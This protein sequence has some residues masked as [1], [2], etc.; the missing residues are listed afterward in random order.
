MRNNAPNTV[1]LAENMIVFCKRPWKLPVFGA[2]A[3]LVMTIIW[4]FYIL[5][6]YDRDDYFESAS[7]LSVGE[8]LFRDVAQPDMQRIYEVT[9][10]AVVGI[11][12]SGANATMV[13]A[14]AIVGA[15]GYVVTT[16]HSVANQAKIRIAVRTAK[17]IRFYDAQVVKSEPGHDLVMLKM[18]TTDRFLFFKMANTENLAV[19]APVFGF[20]VNANGV[21]IIKSG[22]VTTTNVREAVAGMTLTTLLATD[23]VY[24][25]EQSGGPVVNV[26]GELVG[27]GL[28]IQDARGTI[29]GY[30]VPAHVINA[31][32]QDVVGFSAP[33]GQANVANTTPLPAGGQALV[34]AMPSPSAAAGKSPAE[35]PLGSSSWWSMA[36]AQVNAGAGAFGMNIAGPAMPAGPAIGAGTAAPVDADH[37]T[38]FRI[39]GFTLP[40]TL[41]LALLALVVGI[42]GGMMTMGGGILQVA[43]MMTLFGYGIYLVRPVV[44]L[45]NLFVYGAASLHHGKTDTI[46]WSKIKP[47]I[48]WAV[49]G[50]VA[51]YF[52]GNVVGDDAVAILIGLLALLVAVKS[53]HEIVTSDHSHDLLVDTNADK[54]NPRRSDRDDD[55]EFAAAEPPRKKGARRGVPDGLG[56]M[57]AI[58]LPVG[59][60]SGVTGI[61]GGVI[62][63]PVQRLL[64]GM[65]LRN[66]IANS[67][68]LVFWASLAG[69]A[70]AFAHGLSVGLIDW[71]SP[72]L[73]AVIMAPGAYVGGIV[74]TYLLRT[75]PIVLLKWF[76]MATM[77]IVAFKMLYMGL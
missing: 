63:V 68:I 77:A 53:L 43:G 7:G 20:G 65:S 44:Y 28:A 32:F 25:W 27:M 22:E 55:L 52:T 14:G 19:G 67:S 47:A 35:A 9:S 6:T 26:A 2:A 56:W 49:A 70:V 30:A 54:K 18:L 37:S 29:L 61:S 71:Q 10:P 76:Y 34:A 4:G 62:S 23:A 33:G 16:A 46:I 8:F 73:M 59:F 40:T 58:G 60:V 42:V 72:V 51:G 75:L 38:S 50:A 45:T 39:A 74:G 48:P 3:L 17:G 21:P 13:G 11:V 31:H 69:A 57:I 64:A 36:K 41:G 24:S 5:D 1:R 66:A 15:G 12:G